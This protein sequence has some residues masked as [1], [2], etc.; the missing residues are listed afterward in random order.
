MGAASRVAGRR[1][2][3]L[4]AAALAVL[5]LAACARVGGPAPVVAYGAQ[6]S[7]SR[8][9]PPPPVEST[10]GQIVV[11]RG[12]TLYAVSRRTNAPLRALIDANN[13]H[14]PYT[15]QAG[16]RLIVPRV[17]SYRVQPGDTL[18]AVGRRYGVGLHEL[19]AANSLTPPYGLRAGQVLVLPVAG[20]M[21]APSM[22]AVPPTPVQTAALPPPSPVASS[23]VSPIAPPPRA[24]SAVAPAPL[25]APAQAPLA[26]AP[27]SRALPRPAAAPSPAPSA[28]SPAPAAAVAA[29]PMPPA[30]MPAAPAERPLAEPAS[31]TTEEP[32]IPA[33]TGSTGEPARTGHFLWPVNGA[34]V[35]GFGSK[36]GGLQNDGIN[37]AAPRGTPIRAADNG[38][39]VYAGNELRG[40]GNL[41]LIKHRGGWITAY[42]HA[43][44][45]LVHRGDEV[46]RGQIIARVG[47][48]G[49][50]T[51]PQ[52]HFE[53]RK[54]GRPL[55]PQDYLGPQTASAAR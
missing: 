7:S 1:T 41:L 47:N 54:G 31:L 45:L 27:V 5:S 16:Q 34:I 49:G 19:V 48:T 43:E 40:F 28:P 10:A 4:V 53:V 15:L 22:P 11:G 44:Q 42:A 37:I 9:Q 20:G 51:T 50:V 52:L 55:N 2:P 17:R 32:P 12:D 18:S 46:K 30:A 26:E 35:S 14:P 38:V 8:P 3:S 36:P 23:A 13:L 25:A 29:L 39:V 21:T 6:G 33:P 24:V